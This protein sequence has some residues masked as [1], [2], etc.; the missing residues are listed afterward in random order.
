MTLVSLCISVCVSGVPPFALSG[1]RIVRNQSDA[2]DLSAAA[3]TG[4]MFDGLL[5]FVTLIF[6]LYILMII[7]VT[8]K[9]GSGWERNACEKADKEGSAMFH[10]GLCGSSSHR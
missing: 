10:R 4:H 9:C 8:V 6:F 7:A 2:S 5:L 1:Q 3:P